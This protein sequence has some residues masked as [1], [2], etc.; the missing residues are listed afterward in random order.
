[1]KAKD[2]D[3]R[4]DLLDSH[5]AEFE[6]AAE[7]FSE[8]YATC[9]HCHKPSPIKRWKHI[10]PVYYGPEGALA[11]WGDCPRCGKRSFWGEGKYPPPEPEPYLHQDIM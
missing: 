9:G 11:H 4:T 1:M 3:A 2:V 5:H 6:K 7:A 8:I 10:E